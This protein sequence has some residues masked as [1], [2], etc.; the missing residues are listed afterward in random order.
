MQDVWYPNNAAK[1]KAATTKSRHKAKAWFAELTKDDKCL[2]CCESH[3]AC[4]DYHHVNEAQKLFNITRAVNDGV[5]QSKIVN[6]MKKCI[7]LC[8]NC[9][10][11]EHYNRKYQRHCGQVVKLTM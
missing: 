5:A 11:K 8:S 2:R 4:L 6:E 9:H 1:H 7:V 10:R 3:T